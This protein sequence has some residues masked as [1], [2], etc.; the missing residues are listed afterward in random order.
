MPNISHL[1]TRISI[2]MTNEDLE[3][4]RRRVDKNPKFNTISGY[5]RHRLHYDLTRK[6]NKRKK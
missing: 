2:R 5:L 3:I 6:H 4:A 1:T